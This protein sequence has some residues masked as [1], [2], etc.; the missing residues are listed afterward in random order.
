M[1]ESKEEQGINIGQVR[2]MLD[3]IERMSP[4]EHH[5]IIRILHDNKVKYTEND[6]SVAAST[7]SVLLDMVNEQ[8][9]FTKQEK[10]FGEI[11]VKKIGNDEMI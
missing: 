1:E 2:S 7:F 11:F 3:E 5:T 8:K 9:A 10:Q 4:D 6:K